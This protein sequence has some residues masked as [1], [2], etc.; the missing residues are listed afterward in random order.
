MNPDITANI[1]SLP[2]LPFDNSRRRNGGCVWFHGTSCQSGVISITGS[3]LKTQVFSDVGSHADPLFPLFCLWYSFPRQNRGAATTTT[4]TLPHLE[5]V[6][7]TSVC[8][9]HCSQLDAHQLVRTGD[10]SWMT[11]K[12]PSGTEMETSCLLL[13]QLLQ[14]L[15][16]WES[17]YTS[18]VG[19]LVLQELFILTVRVEGSEFSFFSNQFSLNNI[20][21]FNLKKKFYWADIY[22]L[23]DFFFWRGYVVSW[24]HWNRNIT[25]LII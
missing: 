8:R 22:K 7:W 10:V 19:R 11:D 25:V 20:S 23:V 16:D 21:I 14:D 12:M 4:K 9:G 1:V 18:W 2:L 5:S 6:H 13:N 24:E 3:G 15:E 17:T